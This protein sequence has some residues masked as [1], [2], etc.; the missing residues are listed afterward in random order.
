MQ[1]SK[2]GFGFHIGQELRLRTERS[3][4]P[5]ERERGVAGKP[6]RLGDH[7][8]GTPRVFL[9]EVGEDDLRAL[10]MPE[11]MLRRGETSAR[12]VVGVRFA[13]APRRR[14]ARS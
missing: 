2:G 9:D 7:I 10:V 13:L 6:V 8:A 14:R 3:I 4:Q 5:L 11:R 1:C 12:S